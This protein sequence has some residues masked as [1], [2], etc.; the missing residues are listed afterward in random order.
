MSRFFSLK[1]F[2]VIFSA[3]ENLL[4]LLCHPTNIV[5]LKIKR[6]P[7]KL[8]KTLSCYLSTYEFRTKVHF[9]SLRSSCSWFHMDSLFHSTKQKASS[10]YFHRKLNCHNATS[11]YFL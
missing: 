7:H 8:L 2:S 4:S 3:L 1:T 10:N 5:K 11:N 6:T 9:T